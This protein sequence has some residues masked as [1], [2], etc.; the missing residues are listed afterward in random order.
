AVAVYA[1]AAGKPGALV[2][3]SAAAV[4]TANAWNT[5]AIS[6]TVQANASYWLVYNTNGRSASVNEMF[7]D[8]AAAGQGV[9]STNKVTFGT[10]PATFM[11]STL[12]NS[13]FSLF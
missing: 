8:A 1:D 11:A 9:Y 3:S 6:A 5:I 12:T 10:W 7:Y 4:L 2:A 13:Q